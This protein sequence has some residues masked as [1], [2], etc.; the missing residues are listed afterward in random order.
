[1]SS[2]AVLA[3]YSAGYV[4][5][6]PAADRI[7]RQTLERTLERDV[8]AT[9][10]VEPPV[11]PA[12]AAPSLPKTAVVETPKVKVHPVSVKPAVPQE[13]AALPV[14]TEAPVAVTA[15]AAV[16]PPVPEPKTWKDGK[17]AGWGG[18]RHGDIEATVVIEGGRIVS[19]EIS[20]CQTRYPCD[21][22]E[23]LPPQVIARQSANVQRVSGA[24]ES[25]DAF[26]S[27]V[28]FALKQAQ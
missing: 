16:A 6:K 7:A 23:K 24:T 10:V 12:A 11:E 21:V 2:A 5:T 22:I 13:A 19:A 9:K 25:S 20:N 27:A 17:Y 14:E 26:Y 28:Y 8:P 4:R 1:M 18:S 3:V 15:P